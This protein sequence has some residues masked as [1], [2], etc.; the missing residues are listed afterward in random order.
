MHRQTRVFDYLNDSDKNRRVVGEFKFCLDQDEVPA[1]R[2]INPDGSL[3]G[4]VAETAYVDV[5][6]Y[7]DEAATVY[8][9]A[10][11]LGS[12]IIEP[13]A[14]VC[15]NEVINDKD[16]ADVFS[17]WDETSPE[18]EALAAKYEKRIKHN[19]TAKEFSELE[20]KRFEQSVKE[21]KD[22]DE[23]SSVEEFVNYKIDNDELSF[24]T[25]ELQALAHNVDYSQRKIKN[26]LPPSALVKTIKNELVSLGL[27]FVPREPP[28]FTRGAR[29]CS[30]GTH[31][32][33]G[34]GGGGSGMGSGREGSTGFGFGGGPGVMGGGY[35]WDKNDKKN[36]KMCK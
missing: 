24:T 6:A 29:S 19:A 2:H 9:N 31:P 35:K 7:V 32:F 23:L 25:I 18:A 5:S 4:W 1:H 30:H 27:K 12:S 3:G 10:R 20:S 17:T 26:A 14:K 28:K 36:L 22:L 13:F 15:G 16:F 11:V 21:F 8:D 34:S 33:A